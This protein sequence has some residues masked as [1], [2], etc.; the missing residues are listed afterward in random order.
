MFEN[1]LSLRRSLLSQEQVILETDEVITVESLEEE[2]FV[3]KPKT[4]ISLERWQALSPNREVGTWIV[5]RRRAINC[6]A[7]YEKAGRR[8]RDVF[9]KHIDLLIEEI[10]N[11]E[12]AG[13][14][15]YA[16]QHYG[17]LPKYVLRL[18]ILREE[19]QRRDG[20]GQVDV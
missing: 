6:K 5:G 11:E 2:L 19:V 13:L 17:I 15:L 9:V 12:L 3:I 1:V 20:E 18:V 7:R 4:P 14:E 16:K 8:L 10:T